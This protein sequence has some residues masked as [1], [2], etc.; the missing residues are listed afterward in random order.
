[1]L[2]ELDE[3]CNMYFQNAGN[4]LQPCLYNVNAKAN[5]NA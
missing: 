2:P 3:E 5:T 4:Y 1:M